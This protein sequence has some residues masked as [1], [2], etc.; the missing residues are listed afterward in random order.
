LWLAAASKSGFFVGKNLKSAS[1]F[2]NTNS[3]PLRNF[4]YG[5]FQLDGDGQGKSK[6]VK[7]ILE[8]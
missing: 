2:D 4:P 6:I 8:L 7:A 5:S 3:I 1:F